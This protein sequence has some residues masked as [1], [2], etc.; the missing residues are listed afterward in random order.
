MNGLK[1]EEEGKNSGQDEGIIKTMRCHHFKRD[2]G[3]K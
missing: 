1:D 3:R 2:F